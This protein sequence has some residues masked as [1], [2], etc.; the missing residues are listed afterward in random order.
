M[1][2][3]PVRGRGA[4]V[5]PPNRFERIAYERDGD[6]AEPDG[7]G[8]ATQFFKDTARTIVT[9]NNSPDVGFET[10]INTYRG[11]EHGCAYCYARP[12]HEF[13]GLSAGLDFETKIFVKED[14][15]ELL[16]RELSSARWQPRVLAL[17]GVTDPYQPVERRMRLTR[18]LLEVLLEF[19]N[20]VAIVTKNHL[21]ARDADLLAELARHQ[22]AVVFLSIT[23]LDGDLARVLEPRASQ[24]S[25]RLAALAELSRA[26]VPTGV[27]VAPVIPGLT[28]HEMPAVLIAAAKAGASWAGYTLLRLPGAVEPLFADW[29]SRHAPTRKKKVLGRIRSV[30]AGRLNDARFGSRMRGEGLLAEQIARLFRTARQRAGLNQREIHL[31]T[32]AFRRP[33]GTQ[34]LLFD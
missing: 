10:S 2:E 5:N 1:S 4:S 25:G 16:R 34:A 9:T 23:T 18:R 27:M 21:V 29:L 19:R 33:G 24:P 26:G 30:R 13:L 22:A 32:T 7:P 15:P 8:P 12:T 14:A 6:C 28:E 17:S 11:C 31:S 20:P 3:E